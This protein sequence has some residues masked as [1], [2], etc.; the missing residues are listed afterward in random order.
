MTTD[1]LNLRAISAESERAT[2]PNAAQPSSRTGFFGRVAFPRARRWYANGSA[3]P[4]PRECRS[5][6]GARRRRGSLRDAA[7]RTAR[8]RAFVFFSVGMASP[9][10][11]PDI[12]RVW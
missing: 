8:A 5:D 1:G 7:L 10:E 6:A 11:G 3:T 12:G 2:S 4:A 9:P